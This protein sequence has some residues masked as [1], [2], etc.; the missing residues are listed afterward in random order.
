MLDLVV[1]YLIIDF[2]C[3]FYIEGNTKVSKSK[4]NVRV[5]MLKVMF[6]LLCKNN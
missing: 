1:L 3:T 4:I 6:K 2:L 5:N